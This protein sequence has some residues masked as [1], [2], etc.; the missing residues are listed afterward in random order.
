MAD[1][2]PVTLESGHSLMELLVLGAIVAVLCGVAVPS[3]SQDGGR[4]H[5]AAVELRSLLEET[6]TLAASQG[7]FDGPTGPTL[8]VARSTGGSIASI[9]V[10]RPIA[11]Y[12]SYPAREPNMPPLESPVSVE[13]AGDS[14]TA[15]GFSV[16]VSSSGHASYAPWLPGMPKIAREPACPSLGFTLGFARGASGESH[17]LT[18][19]NAR[20][21]P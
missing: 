10:G 16:F 3:L 13:V 2:T 18:C 19:E 4:V 8:V 20:L 12:S 15:A 6:R 9:Y 21:E 11:A 14:R 1:R 7:P 17:V 5:L